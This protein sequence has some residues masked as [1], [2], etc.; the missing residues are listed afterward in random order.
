MVSCKWIVLG[1]MAVMR[2]FSFSQTDLETIQHQRYHHPRPRVQQRME[3]LWLKSQG[4]T[5]EQIGHL[6]D[7]SRRTV[8][9]VLD[10]Y[11]AGGIEQ[12]RRLSFRRPE[13]ALLKHKGTLEEYFLDNPPA[14]AAQAQAMIEKL[15]G[16]KRGLTQVR[17]FL[18]SLD[19][20]YRKVGSIPAKANVEEQA[21]FL[22]TRLQPRLAQAQQ[23]RRTVLFVDAA[24]FIYGPFLGYLWC[25]VRLFIR[26]PAGRQRY[27]V[28]AALDAITHQV[29]RVTNTQYINAESVCLLLR[30]IVAANVPRPITL[31]L[32]NARYQHCALVEA[33]AR[34]LKIELLFLPSYSPNLNLIERLW[35]FV[36]KECLACKWM[37]DFD[38]FTKAI[39]NCLSHLHTKHKHQ[40]DTLLTLNFQT[41]EDEPFV[42]A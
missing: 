37:E 5:H 25:L 39:D 27:N 33:L 21:E 15:T 38:T 32:D 13:S 1:D 41:F 7:V 17:Q 14:S 24:H 2:T 18:K 35:K 4:I 20:R 16:I 8:Q 6:A 29:Y 30:Q 10:D 28:L 40:M 22:E 23:G 42:A 36:K 19:L 26:A 31:V 34:S 3:V 11:L 12:V 9:R